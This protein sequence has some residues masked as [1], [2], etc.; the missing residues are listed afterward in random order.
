MN[1]E[2]FYFVCFLVGFLLSLVTFMAGSTHL[3]TPKGLHFHGAH[4]HG[5]G[6]GQGHH[7]TGRGSDRGSQISWF[8]FGTITAFLAWFGGTGYL[9]TRYSNIWALL[10]LGISGLSGLGGAAL[11]FWF[12][13]KILLAHEQ[14][15]DPADYNMI[16]VLGQVSSGIREGG[17][18]E[19]IFSQQGIRR[20]V[21]VRSDTGVPIAKGAEV[22]VIRYEKGIAYVRLWEELNSLNAAS[23]LIPDED[24]Q[25]SH[26][27]IGRGQS[28][29]VN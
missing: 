17:T 23:P 22:V 26:R 27:A 10:G 24:Q 19:M 29:T 11:V 7:G 12:V 8:N 2:I 16:G 18:G 25:R 15:L 5:H 3:H 6:V 9:L 4:G 20:C 14:D 1:W 21:A 28:E 13:F